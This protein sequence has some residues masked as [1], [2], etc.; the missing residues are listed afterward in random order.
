MI[1]NPRVLMAEMKNDAETPLM[2]RCQM[3]EFLEAL[4]C[5]YKVFRN[6]DVG[7]GSKR[8]V[9]GKEMGGGPPVC[10]RRP[11]GTRVV[12]VVCVREVGVKPQV[13]EYKVG[14]DICRSAGR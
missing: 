11:T 5:I 1:S 2:V 3:R 9:V 7:R 4:V 8:S 14:I 13:R 10:E 6:N 12:V